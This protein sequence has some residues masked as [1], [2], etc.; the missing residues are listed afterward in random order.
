[1]RNNPWSNYDSDANF[2][3][4]GVKI[5]FG[6]VAVGFVVIVAFWIFMAVTVVKTADQV[7]QRGLKAV[8]EDV[9]CGKDKHCL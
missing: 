3:R 5:V 6:I 2:V 1:M 7:E 8:V 4:T 9:W